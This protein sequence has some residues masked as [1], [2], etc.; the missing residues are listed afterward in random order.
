MPVLVPVHDDAPLSQ[1]DLLGDVHLYITGADGGPT[2]TG[3][4]KFGLVISRP[5]AAANREMVLVAGVE[6]FSVPL[7]KDLADRVKTVRQLARLF[8][9]VRDADGSDAMYLG[10]LPGSTDGKRYAA[11]LDFVATL[12]VPDG[13]ARAGWID[14]HRVGRL[15]PSFRRDLHTRFFLAVAKQGFDDE[16]WYSDEDLDFIVSFG[17]ARLGEAQQAERQAKLDIQQAKAAG[18]YARKRR[19]LDK[20]LTDASKRVE[21]AGTELVGFKAEQ[22]QRGAK[23]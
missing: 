7:P 11:R 17:D 19:G 16:S 2:E 15:E 13:A 1:G 4:H 5:C 6:T 22:A 18:D 20:A 9:E 10:E 8:A 14:S 21:A 23:G 12:S 3:R